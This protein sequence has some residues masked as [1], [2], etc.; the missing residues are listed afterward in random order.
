MGNIK[1]DIRELKKMRDNL[2]R[3]VD[4]DINSFCRECAKELAA[5]LLRKVILKTPV[6]QY[7]K[8]AGKNGGTLRRVWTTENAN[9]IVYRSGKL[10]CVNIVNT[11]TYASYVEYGHRKV[12]NR[13]WVVGQFMMTKSLQELENQM[14]RILDRKLE[15]FLGGIFDVK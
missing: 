6:G 9:L 10:F 3:M 11:T 14:Q 15:I 8:S 7:P 13:G 1:I 5:R 2:K 12:N 4:S